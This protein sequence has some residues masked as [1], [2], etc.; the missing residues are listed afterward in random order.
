MLICQNW[1]FKLLNFNCPGTYSCLRVKL[2]FCRQLS[3]FIV[4]VY[5]PCSMTVSV[6]WMSFW[7]DHKAV[8]EI[9]LNFPL[10]HFP[11]SRSQ[12]GWHWEWRPCW[13][14]RPPRPAYRTPCPPWPTP[15]PSTSGPGSV[16]SL[17]SGPCWSMQWWTTPPGKSCGK[18]QTTIKTFLTFQNSAQNFNI[19]IPQSFYFILLKVQKCKNT[20]FLEDSNNKMLYIYI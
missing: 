2:L 3:F 18:C 11:L 19:W 16:S 10:F 5:V 9:F 17:S 14:C 1:G 13:P 20:S 15:R 12:P 4:T 7:L 8:S 6:S